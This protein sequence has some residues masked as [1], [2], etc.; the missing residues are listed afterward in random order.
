MRSFAAAVVT[1]GGILIALLPQHALGI[2]QLVLL[3]IAA[4]AGLHA[5]SIHVPQTGWL[6]PF[7]WLSPFAD[8]ARPARRRHGSDE[9]DSI[10]SRLAGRR[11]TIQGSA[12]LPPEAIRLLQP[13][14]QTTLGVDPSDRRQM[15]R[16]RNRLSTATWSILA[17]APLVRPY[18]FRTVRPNQWEVAEVVHDVLDE[19][20]RLPE[21]ARLPS[22]VNELRAQDTSRGAIS[23]PP[24]RDP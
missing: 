8:P 19:L 16:A 17:A 2:V 5:L 3:S 18:W 4:G 14:I 10:R 21:D 13:V 23:E 15:M 12:P 24:P 7:K 9:M 22:H 6:S 11:Q 20:E 1:L